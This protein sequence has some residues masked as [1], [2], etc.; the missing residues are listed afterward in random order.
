MEPLILAI[1]LCH[2]SNDYSTNLDCSTIQIPTDD[3]AATLR[4]QKEKYRHTEKFVK[5]A[6][7]IKKQKQPKIQS[8]NSSQQ[9]GNWRL[10]T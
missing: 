6:L 7:C 8:G 3:C 1:A 10:G 9:F 4:E 5:M 2:F